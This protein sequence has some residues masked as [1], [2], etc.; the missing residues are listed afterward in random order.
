M[1]SCGGRERPMS[2]QLSSAAA[3]P[4]VPGPG[5][6]VPA[7]KNVATVQAQYGRVGR[8]EPF[9]VC[10]WMC[11]ANRGGG[12]LVGLAASMVLAFGVWSLPHTS[13]APLSRLVVLGF[14]ARLRIVYRRGDHVAPADPFAEVDDP[15][16]VRAERKIGLAGQ[17]D[18]AAG[19]T[20]ERWRSFPGHVSTE[21]V[22]NRGDRQ[23]AH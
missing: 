8:T 1:R 19:G 14:A 3:E 5:L 4:Q 9:L 2:I 11:W 21:V 23:S 10:R 22:Y 15:A 12:V 13:D 17:H 18:L 16:A 6:S 7:P 20:T